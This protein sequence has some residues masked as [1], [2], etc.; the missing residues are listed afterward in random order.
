MAGSNIPSVISVK[1]EAARL[2][3]AF[4]EWPI[5]WTNFRIRLLNLLPN[6]NFQPKYANDQLVECAYQRVRLAPG[7][8]AKYVFNYR[9]SARS[10]D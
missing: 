4:S 8:A 5:F 2:I 6:A 3:L 7:L 9:I 10:A 1:D